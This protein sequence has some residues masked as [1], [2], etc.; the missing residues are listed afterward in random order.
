MAFY[1]LAG[2]F[3]HDPWKSGD[4]I[5]LAIARDF[6]EGTALSL[7]LTGGSTPAAPLYYWSA[8]LTGKLF[9]GILPL[10]DAMRLASGLWTALTLLA[11][12]H[13]GREQYGRESAA[14][15][16]L[17][18]AG[19][20]GF[21]IR[22]HEAQPLLTLVAA[23]CIALWAATRLPRKPRTALCWM[24]IALIMAGLGSDLAGLFLLLFVC[25][26]LLF[27]AW[28]E[29]RGRMFLCGIAIA[30]LLVLAWL[31]G[32]LGDPL[33]FATGVPHYLRNLGDFLLLLPWFSWPLLPLAGWSLWLR[34]RQLSAFSPAF[35][36]LWALVF[37][38][39]LLPLFFPAAEATAMLLLPPLALLATPGTLA[40]RRG[41]A[42][43]FDWFS[44]M[45]F[46]VFALLLWV[47]W[48][49]MIFGWPRRLAERAVELEPGFVGRFEFSLFA[50]AL[51]VT[52]WWLWNL[53]TLPRSPYRSLVRWTTGL[54]V[55]WVLAA[56]LWLPWIDYGKSY[57][58]L[59]ARL[60]GEIPV[61]ARGCV[62]AW[63]LGR[64]QRASLI[65]F[66][67]LT[68]MPLAAHDATAP[69]ACRWLITQG[70]PRVETVPPAPPGATWQRVWEGQR[71]GD[72]RERF[73][74]YQL[75]RASRP[76]IS[77]EK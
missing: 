16:S 25:L 70:V 36:S 32:R 54:T 14:A 11:L 12:Y 7:P 2:L 64:A 15:T 23:L 75:R 10:H 59:A 6:L 17:L 24:G 4:V 48:S 50:L 43:A 20:L 51:L 30:S 5:H 22:A 49:A 37:L 52:L 63:R 77:N 8:A 58:G 66:E 69:A 47:G 68:L 3:G 21:L 31:P 1:A 46:S 27:L 67:R 39:L 9:S 38:L 61:D 33:L 35:L 42:N 65:Y 56:F 72:R 73:R 13:A 29:R 60:V 74:L 28:Q 53:T 18:L 41:A 57:R 62:L 40:L 19:S 34:R 71:P 76:V 55:V 26:A 45:A 44:S